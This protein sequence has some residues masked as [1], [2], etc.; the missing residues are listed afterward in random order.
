MPEY[1]PRRRH[2]CV[3]TAQNNGV[4]S[5]IVDAT[6]KRS[7]L[8]DYVEVV[9]LTNQ[10]KISYRSGILSDLSDFVCVDLKNNF[11]IP[12]W[13]AN[14]TTIATTNETAH[15]VTDFLLARIPG[16]LKLY[17]GSDTADNETLYSIEFINMLIPSEFT[18]HILK[19]KKKRC[20]M[21]LKNVDATN[22]HCNGTHYIIVSL[23]DHVIEA[24]VAS[25]PCA[26]STLLIP[27]IPH[28]SQEMEF[29]FPF[30]CK[31]FPLKPAFVLTCNKAE[32]QT[33]EQIGI[34]LPRQFFSHGQL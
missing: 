24:K 26:G 19:L 32:G 6:L 21:L 10:S 34:Y 15:F 33:F 12:V 11:T 16:K 20:I 8:C 31:Q 13:L 2:D 25:G 28:V 3:S 17:R 1:A 4:R 30:T 29:P 22:G 7:F 5:Q 14:R 27:R 9:E 18:A 23:Y